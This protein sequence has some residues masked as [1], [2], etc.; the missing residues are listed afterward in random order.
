MEKTTKQ[1]CDFY[2]FYPFPQLDEKTIVENS[3]KENSKNC[4][5]GIPA[6]LVQKPIKVLDVGCGTGSFA[7]SFALANPLSEVTATNVSQM[8]LDYAKKQAT[9]LGIKNINFI[10]ADIFD[11]PKDVA[12]KQYEIVYCSGV[13]H[14]TFNPF[15]GL[16]E[17]SKLVKPEHYMVIGLYHKGRYKVR[18][19]RLVLKVLARNNV[20]KRIK[21]ARILFP[22]HC[23]HHVSKVFEIGTKTRELE[24]ITL[25][26]K[27]AVPKESYHSFTATNNYLDKLGYKNIYKNVS[28][29]ENRFR[30]TRLVHKIV[31]C[32]PCPKRFKEDLADDIIALAIGKEMFLI[33]SKKVAAD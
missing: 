7:L 8:S 30:G 24:D 27:F 15:L 22:K 9:S 26:D 11:L 17:L 31:S 29:P 1:V 20:E 10:T 28:K 23:H 14:H 4:S 21:L 18:A 16:S 12:S 6:E 13:L 19:M 3:Q 5:I 32:F 33:T 25:A 2:D